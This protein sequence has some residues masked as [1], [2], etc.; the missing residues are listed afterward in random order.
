MILRV[1]V[2]AF[3]VYVVVS[4]VQMTLQ[5]NAME[6]KVA[7]LNAQAQVVET[8][9]AALEEKIENYSAHLEQQAREQGMAK[10]GETIFVEIPSV[11]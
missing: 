7:V 5:L 9:K 10:P 4:I 1:A 3:A 2:L 11:E 8:N 6:E